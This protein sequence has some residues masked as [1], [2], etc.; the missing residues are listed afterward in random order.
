MRLIAQ[1]PRLNSLD[2]ML[3]M[4]LDGARNNYEIQAAQMPFSLAEPGLVVVVGCLDSSGRA[5]TILT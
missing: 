1:E 5:W 3:G 4:L 2:A